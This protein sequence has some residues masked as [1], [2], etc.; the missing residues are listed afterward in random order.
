MGPEKSS[1]LKRNW[2]KFG[3]G[4]G[5][6]ALADLWE[7]KRVSACISAAS[8]D[9]G[10]LDR[11]FLG[12]SSLELLGVFVENGDFY[13]PVLALVPPR[14][15]DGPIVAEARGVNASTVYVTAVDEVTDHGAS[16]GARKFPVRGVEMAHLPDGCVIGVPIH[17][18]HFSSEVLAVDDLCNFVQDRLTLDRER[19]LAQRE[20]NLVWDPKADALTGARDLHVAVDQELILEALRSALLRVR[21]AYRAGSC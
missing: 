17:A 20:E 1:I 15:R 4:T 14:A 19:R 11:R 3:G 5:R 10:F 12:P 16:P 7:E 13:S 21:R 9:R 8:A 18:D 6:F 2:P